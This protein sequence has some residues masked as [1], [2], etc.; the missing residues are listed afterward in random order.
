MSATTYRAPQKMSKAATDIALRL[1]S[2]WNAA[3]LP[4]LITG[5]EAADLSREKTGVVVPGLVRYQTSNCEPVTIAKAIRCIAV[6]QA[7]NR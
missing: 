5:R 1:F 7:A 6:Y 3:G 2:E 4:D